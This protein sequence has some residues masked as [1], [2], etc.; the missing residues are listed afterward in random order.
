M[1]DKYGNVL[2]IGATFRRTPQRRAVASSPPRALA[3]GRV[4]VDDPS[5]QLFGGFSYLAPFSAD[6]Y[7]QGYNLDA[8]TLERVSPSKLMELLADLSPD[9][10]RA[11]WDFLLMCSPGYECKAYKPGTTTQD[12]NAQ[13]AID[14]FLSNLHGVYSVPN[15]TPAEVVIASLFIQPFLRG[16]FC[17]EL[18]LDADGKTPLEIATPDPTTIRFKRTTDPVRG[19]AWQMIQWQLGEETILDRPTICYVPVHPFPGKPYGRPLATPALFTTLFLLSVLH[20]VRRVVQQQGMPRIDI[21]VDFT[22]LVE[23]MPAE[24]QGDPRKKKAWLDGA[25]QEI[26]SMYRNLEPDDAYVHP[27]A[28]KVNRPIGAADSSSLGGIDALIKGLERMAC[29][30]L[31]SMPLL[32]ATTDGVSEANAN[33]QWEIYVAGIKSIQHL[34]ENLLER[35][36]TLALQAQGIAAKVEFRFAELRAAELL[37][38]AQVDLLNVTIARAK[39]DNGWIS[40]DKAAELG[41]GVTKADQ[42]E[43]RAQGNITTINPDA[44]LKEQAASDNPDPGSNRSFT[45]ELFDLVKRHAQESESEAV[46]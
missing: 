44:A 38:D 19:G 15:V 32:M 30:A 3:G 36:L 7:W 46:N 6:E 41:A 24:D 40:Q 43:P 9:V 13:A 17:A 16:A 8:R 35:L 29:R 42:S 22:K 21:A 5:L 10:S 28:V 20:D 37:R 12:K 23:M 25:F 1:A 4:S 31:K 2:G 26:M 45:A 33:R 27:D 14:Q 18:V 39:Y 34:C 11:L